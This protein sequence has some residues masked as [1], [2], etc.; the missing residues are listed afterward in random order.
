MIIIGIIYLKLRKA[1]PVKNTENVESAERKEDRNA[2]V[3]S[4]ATLSDRNGYSH[5]GIPRS[6]YG[7]TNGESL[8]DSPYEETG[9]DSGTYEPEPVGRNGNVVTINGVAVR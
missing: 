8:Y 6:M 7:N 3:M 4:Y 2:A 9:R 1:T 5:S